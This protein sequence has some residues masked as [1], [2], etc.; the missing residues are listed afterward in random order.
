[1]RSRPPHR[2]GE[3]GSNEDRE[4]PCQDQIVRLDAVEEARQSYARRNVSEEVRQA[5]SKNIL[6]G[7]ETYEEGGLRLGADPLGPR[8]L[9]G[10]HRRSQRLDEA[11]PSAEA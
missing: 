2:H 11:R 7:L 1:M 8:V 5:R 3:H 10:Q 9:F 6:R 4:P